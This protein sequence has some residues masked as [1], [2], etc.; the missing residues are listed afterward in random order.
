MTLYVTNNNPGT[1]KLFPVQ[2]EN[3]VGASFAK[4][5]D[6]VSES[7][8]S[9]EAPTRGFNFDAKYLI[10]VRN[11]PF[12]ATRPHIAELF[13]NIQLMNGME[14]IHFIMT[15]KITEN[16]E[17]FIQLESMRDYKAALRMT[18]KTMDDQCIEGVS[19]CV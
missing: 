6:Y 13:E 10:Q 3:F 15:D 14:G 16:V 1:N 12:T 7:D 2:L 19:L 9:F 18:D 4:V 5:K 17:A 11:L 8:F